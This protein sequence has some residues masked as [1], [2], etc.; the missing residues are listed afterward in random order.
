[1][2]KIVKKIQKIWNEAES[3]A[4]AENQSKSG[5]KLNKKQ[6]KFRKTQKVLRIKELIHNNPK[7][8]K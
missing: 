6:N 5:E 3:R 2:Q 4:T 1:M 8:N 7:L